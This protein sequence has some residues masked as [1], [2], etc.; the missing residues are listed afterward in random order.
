MFPFLKE[1]NRLATDYN[2]AR[3]VSADVNKEKGTIALMLRLKEPAPPYEISIIEGIIA[4]EFGIS[5]VSITAAFAQ[6]VPSPALTQKPEQKQ[7]AGKTKR[8][9]FRDGVVM[10]RDTKAAPIPMREVTLDH[11][12]VKI[13]GEVC[14][15]R[16]RYIEKSDA[17]LLSFDITD[18]T[19]AINVTKFMQKERFERAEIVANAIELGMHLTVSGS[20]LLSKYDN[21]LTLAPDNIVIIE[22]ETRADTAEEKRV[23]LHLHTKMSAMDA[24]I[25]V[26]TVIR[27]AVEWGHPAIA[28][29]DHGVV[30][31]FP[32]AAAAVKELKDKIKVIYGVE[33]YFRNDIDAKTAEEPQSYDT[34]DTEER[35]LSNP[36]NGQTGKKKRTRNNHIIL[37]VKNETGLRNLYKLITISHLEHFSGKPIIKKSVLVR[38]REGLII[39]S[40]CESGELF[41]AIVKKRNDLELKR[42]AGFYDYLE[43]QPICNN[44]FMLEG[45]KP[46]ASSE[47]ELRD[48]NR[49]VVALGSELG[50]PVVATGDAHFLDPEHEI[51]RHVLLTFKEFSGANNEL[52]IFFKTT[53]EMLEEFSYLGEETAYE[54]VIKNPCGIA[55]ECGKVDPLPPSKKLFTPKLEGSADD[56]KELV[57]TR[58]N[59]LYGESPPERITKRVEIELHD[60]LKRN[61]D[62]IY[63]SAQKIVNSAIK[64]GHIVGSRGSV[65]SSF[66]AFLAGITEVNALPAHYRCPECK[67][68]EFPDD[69]SHGAAME[70]GD[71]SLSHHY[72]CGADM[73]KKTCLS[74]GTMLF[75]DGFNIPFE[76]FLGFD[77]KKIPDIDLNF[78][79][80]DKTVAHKFT[81]DLFGAENVYRAGTIGTLA[82]KN[83]YKAVMKYLE[84]HNRLASRA[85]IDYLSKG[86]DGVKQTTG[87]HP[88][89]LVVIPKDMDITDFCPAQHPADDPDKGVIT[90]HFDYKCM[91]DNLVKF[92]M[93][94]HGNPM[95]IKM[96]EEMTGIDAG[97]IEFDDPDTM[98]LFTSPTRLGLPED[99]PII[100]KTG[101][102][103][104]P[105]FGTVNARDM[106]NDAQPKDFDT[107]IR[108]SGFSHGENVWHGNAK[109]LIENGVAID[110]TIGCRDD[111]MLTLKSKGIDERT[112][113]KI[114]ESVRKGDGLPKGAEEEMLNHDVPVWYIESCNKIK[115]LFPKAH[116]TAYV[117]EAFRIAWF[118]VNHPLEYYSAYFCRRG[119]KSPGF[120]V[121]YMAQ[122]INIVRSRIRE[123]KSAVNPTK[124]DEELLITLES[125]YEFYM[126]G[127][128]FTGID[129]YESDPSRFIIVGDNKLRP[130]FIAINGLGE[131][132]A[133]D[134]AKQ[135]LN[136]KFVSMDDISAA[137]SS[138]TKTHLEQLKN[139][140]ALRGL[141]ETSQ[142]SL[143]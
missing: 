101:T 48:F 47:E 130:P 98:S 31:S 89:G 44:R 106:L 142:M 56:L 34:D 112:A 32:E 93:L 45:D 92:D 28:I 140:G 50:K 24:L 19:G 103:G 80:T 3:V 81:N 143:F 15:V 104:I 125:C 97:D 99:N 74:C 120:D 86:C 4:E 46:K 29:T 21:E 42:I 73:P 138:V 90:T 95:M 128:D 119:R 68:V 135:R 100:G 41:D 117:M 137:C 38:H 116:A 76:T 84:F 17:W 23:E 139:I 27:R 63:M 85:E 121:E 82:D 123:V 77:G 88:G 102:I 118:K 18:N 64:Q 69:A 124:K 55:D 62:V 16:S 94:G 57:Y 8:G 78:A 113:F 126:R 59:E 10:G 122:G 9:R 115:Y 40:A 7:A 39:G 58:L 35:H 49:K 136:R 108:L 83:T 54:I 66:I 70:T 51:F 26:K 75:R 132:A 129:L 13:K 96:L 6:P 105:E 109:E 60:I 12:K 43:V 72:A 53:D 131:A 91:E 71:G 65:G 33:G 36:A 14:E 114:S 127:F 133:N 11:G 141:P 2:E 110:K 37:L 20:I 25:D 52:P 30:Q 87:Q 79:G 5:K 22:K 1:S 107:L 67:R 61:Y 111:I 134:L